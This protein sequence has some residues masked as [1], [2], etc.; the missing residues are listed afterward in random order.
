[1]RRRHLPL[2]ALPLAAGAARAL[3]FR[4]AE[5]A[6]ATAYADYRRALF[7][8]NQ[9][10]RGASEQALL[11]FGA[12]WQALA[13]EWRAAPPPQY[14]EDAALG[15]T[16]DAVARIAERA[17]AE[18]RRG[19]LPEAHETLEAIRDALGELRARNGVT[20]FS[21]RMN[22]YHARMEELLE[23]PP[24]GLARLRVEAAVLAYLAGD[25]APPPREA[26]AGFAPALEAVRASVAALQAA[27]EAG[28]P[29]AI[30]AALAGLKPPYARLFLRYG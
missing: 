27:L 7:A 20:G 6:V 9:G 16:L 22:A 15:A 1:M 30:R 8:T 10:D 2:L 26:D 12:K 18:T 13:A 14:A 23:L 28:E 3:P 24:E 29:A 21:D 4:D 25:L 19:A 11:R 17:L 5:A